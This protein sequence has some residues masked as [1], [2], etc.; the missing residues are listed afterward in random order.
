MKV[1]TDKKIIRKTISTVTI[2]A[3]LLSPLT[4]LFAA[5]YPDGFLD[6]GYREYLSGKIQNGYYVEVFSEL[7]RIQK[8]RVNKRNQAE[9]ILAYAYQA[10]PEAANGILA[11]QYQHQYNADNLKR[12]IM[13]QRQG[14]ENSASANLE[15]GFR[16][17][18][19]SDGKIEY[20]KDGLL[21]RVENERVVDE[22]GNVNIR[23]S[24]N[25]KYDGKRLLTGFEADTKD[26]LGNISHT[27]QYGMKYTADSLFYAGKDT[28]ANKNITEYFL[29]ETDPAGN[30]EV[31]HFYAGSYEGKL[32]RAFSQTIEDNIYG[33]SSFNR[34]NI[35]YAG[36]DPTRISSYHE[37]GIGT[38]NLSYTSERA[39]MRYNDKGQLTGYQQE[40]TTTQIDGKKTKTSIEA[41]FN[42]LGVPHQ[43][44]RDVKE[45]DPDRI[46]ESIVTSSEEQADGSLITETNTTKYSYNAASQFIDTSSQSEFNGQEANWYEYKDASG[47]TLSRNVDKENK[48]TYS[49]VDPD[50]LETVTVSG[51]L[52]SAALKDGNKFSGTTKTKF[53]IL[54]G[55]PLAKET[56]SV[57]T[58]SN[59]ED[60]N[61]VRT[62]E[63]TVTYNNGLVNNL[64]RTLGSQEHTKI[65]NPALDPEKSHTQVRNINSSYLY[66]AKGNISDVDSSGTGSGWEY[67]SEKGWHGKYT[68]NINI[69]Y[70]VVSGRALRKSYKEDKDYE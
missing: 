63:S 9:E 46:L 17:I 58:Y 27:R 44:G 60:N 67:S 40:I 59:S 18:P 70:E 15:G 66:D 56:Q 5:D 3:L 7:D 30:K 42:Y 4:I 48:V 57:T 35:N 43:F 69:D 68:S 32:L 50:T 28:N 64:L 53:E 55:K 61:I 21:T 29:E 1:A 52:V 19:H 14:L 25:Y 11:A 2:L 54:Y 10:A 65:T 23:N 34:S 49:Y 36:G 6:P 37:E 16:Y 41:K 8:E 20:F 26:A 39:D 22:F 31:T 24:Y 62:E 38:D 33:K 47:H 45:P 12:E 13:L 51:D